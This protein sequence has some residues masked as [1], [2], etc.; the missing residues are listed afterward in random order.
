MTERLPRITAK[1]VLKVLE[2]IGFSLARQSGSHMIYKNA[3]GKRITIPYHTGKILHLKL[4]QS[5]LK[6]ANLTLE[7]FKEN[8]R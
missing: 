4:L 3:E 1:D 7:A 5:I 8:L 2:Q 6:D